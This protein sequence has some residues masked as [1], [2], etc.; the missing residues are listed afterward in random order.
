VRRHV[1]GLIALGFMACAAVIFFSPP[2][3]LYQAAA[4]I[5]L[6]VGMLLGVLWLAWPDLHK[7]P[8]WAWYVLPIAALALVFAQRILL[9]VAPVL[10]G[11]ILI[12]LL[13]RRVWRSP[14]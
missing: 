9:Y 13:Y 7:L 14:P 11:A 2:L 1:L 8:R 3:A 10:A 4:G 6:R 12:Y 5:G